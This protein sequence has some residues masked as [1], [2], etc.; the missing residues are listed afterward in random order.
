MNIGFFITSFENKGGIERLVVSLG[1]GLAKRG[2]R[3]TLFHPENISDPYPVPN[4][5]QRIKLP[6]FKTDNLG[7]VA[8]EHLRASDFDVLC[9]LCCDNGGRLFLSQCHGLNIP[10]VWSEH[11]APFAIEQDYWNRPERL[12]CMASSDAVHLLCRDFLASIPRVLQKRV[13]I[14]PNCVD[15]KSIII[16]KTSCR[17]KRLLTVARLEESQKQ[18]SFLISAFAKLKDKFP[19]WNCHICGEGPARGLY[20]ELIFWHGLKA[21]WCLLAILKILLQ[22][23][24]LLMSLFFLRAMKDS[25]L[26]WLKPNFLVFQA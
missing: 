24:P 17:T 20:K 16:A 8:K 13:S 9:I 7:I 21:A 25:G 23:M 6:A 5:V 18:L 15:L 22:N 4:D 11:N 3:C 12:L 26:P 10:I 19:D 1:D 14:I 2:H